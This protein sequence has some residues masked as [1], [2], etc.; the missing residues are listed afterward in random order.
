MN[1]LFSFFM[2]IFLGF[3]HL[4][5]LEADPSP[6]KRWDF[7]DE[8]YWIHNAR[9]ENTF[10]NYHLDDM[11]MSRFTAPL[12]NKLVSN[13][14]K[15]FGVSFFSARIISIFFLWLT[16][17]MM[18]ILLREHFGSYSSI[19][20][21]FI[22]GF[23]HEIIMV[24]K[25]ATPLITQ[26]TFLLGILFF[27]SYKNKSNIFCF[28]AGV[29]YG[30]AFLSKITSI[31][32]LPSLLLF[33]ILEIISKKVTIKNTFYFICG[34][35]IIVVPF[36]II[37][38][39]PNFVAYINTF[40]YPAYT[41]GHINIIG[42]II[43]FFSI[44][45]NFTIFKSPSSVFIFIMF[46]IY[47]TDKI[48]FAKQYSLKNMVSEMSTIEKFS[49]CWIFGIMLGL[50]LN[51]QTYLDRRMMSLNIPTFMLSVFCFNNFFKPEKINVFYSNLKNSYSIMLI[52]LSI[53]LLSIYYI[54]ITPSN[55]L[56][57][58]VKTS[59]YFDSSIA[60]I[61]AIA[62]L[63][64]FW[65]K[66]LSNLKYFLLICS[67]TASTFLNIIW[68]S[69]HTF[70]I[71][72][73][74]KDLPKH[75]YNI[76]YITGYIDY[77][78]AFNSVFKPIWYWRTYNDNDNFNKWFGD[79]IKNERFLLISSSGNSKRYIDIDMYKPEQIKLLKKINLCPLPNTKK[80]RS[81]LNLYEINY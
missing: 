8:G 31:L 50:T 42:S 18:F 55:S 24:A 78:L 57:H 40:K 9:I 68:F 14:F 56:S 5:H 2:L 46:L 23:T 53:F 17:L 77:H 34:I 73:A 12:Y 35:S 80:F 76:K 43:S 36:L 20:S 75:V 16:L 28:I 71:R 4:I 54:F 33:L 74:M 44:P 45:F 11:E 32:F 41:H 25:W 10:K 58:W 6:I 39:A 65:Y 64:F 62:V 47:I 37:L 13:S 27:Y 49:I 59:V 72:D 19:I 61:F 1:K 60:F 30:L 67:F 69:N 48:T 3:C 22:F 15:N 81:E 51:N 70:T 52:W 38:F 21:V 79:Y 63:Y 66:K 26:M 29:S 7:S